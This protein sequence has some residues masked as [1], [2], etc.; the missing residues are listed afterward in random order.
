[1]ASIADQMGRTPWGTRGETPGRIPLGQPNDNPVINDT[2]VQ[3]DQVAEADH[4]IEYNSY[5][6]SDILCTIYVPAPRTQ[7]IRDNGEGGVAGNGVISVQTQLQTLTVSSARSVHPVRTLGTVNPQDYTRGGRTIAGSMIYTTLFRDALVEAYQTAFEQAETD[8]AKFFVDQIPK[9]NML[10][11]ASNEYGHTANTVLLGIHISNFGTTFSVDD[12]YTE[13]TYTY[14][15]DHFYPFVEDPVAMNRL[16]SSFDIEESASSLVKEKQLA[17][18][19]E[20]SAPLGNPEWS[21]KIE[22]LVLVGA[23]RRV[24]RP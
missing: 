17:R 5:A 15:A 2:A 21:A 4:S 14:V 9:F 12:M 24:F 16:L 1:M 6:G 8:S 19:A 20:D 13:S 7:S 23:I 10:I 18:R 11:N 22:D 3:F